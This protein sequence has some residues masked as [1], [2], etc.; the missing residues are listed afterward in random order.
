VC[1]RPGASA[2][3]VF[4]LSTLRALHSPAQN[5]AGGGTRADAQS[6]IQFYLVLLFSFFSL[7]NFIIKRE[8]HIIYYYTDLLYYYTDLLYYYTDLLYYYTDLLYYYTDLLYYYTDLLYYYTDLL[9]YYTDLLYYYTDLLYYYTD[10]LYYYR[11]KIPNLEL[12]LFVPTPWCL[13]PLG[14][15]PTHTPC[16]ILPHLPKHARRT[17]TLLIFIIREKNLIYIISY[18]YTLIIPDFALGFGPT[19]S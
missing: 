18:L 5:P 17:L 16:K 11:E 13:R 12:T 7:F 3:R 4:A 8:N 14:F 1:V 6:Y 9:Y 2:C 15:L 19:F 10:L